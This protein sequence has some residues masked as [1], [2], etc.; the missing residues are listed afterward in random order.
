MGRI[1]SGGN[2]RISR[3][4]WSLRVSSSAPQCFRHLRI[5][6]LSSASGIGTYLEARTTREN[7]R[8]GFVN[9]VWI[10]LGRYRF[11]LDYLL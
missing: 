2:V 4:S 6:R 1:H 5:D 10:Y 11:E 8:C 9:Y 7:S 3:G